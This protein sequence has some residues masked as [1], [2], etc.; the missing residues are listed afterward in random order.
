MVEPS[1]D[2]VVRVGAKGGTWIDLDHALAQHF[3]A[4]SGLVTLQG[5]AFQSDPDGSPDDLSLRL[6]G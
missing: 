4:K 2:L 1:E 3:L 5:W 6:T